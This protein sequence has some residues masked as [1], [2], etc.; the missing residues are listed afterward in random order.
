M[1]PTELDK[2]QTGLRERSTAMYQ[3][4]TADRRA[5]AKVNRAARIKRLRHRRRGPLG[6]LVV[7]LL[8]DFENRP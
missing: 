1:E 5:L 4:A 2:V 7:W 6:R 3:A 8:G